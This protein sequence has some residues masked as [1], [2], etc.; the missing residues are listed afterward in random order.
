MPDIWILAP[1]PNGVCCDCSTR[2]N[3]CDSCQG[4]VF[5]IPVPQVEG[6]D[7]FV[8]VGTATAIVAA[9]KASFTESTDKCS[10][11]SPFANPGFLS[12]THILLTDQGFVHP[13]NVSNDQ[14]NSFVSTST[15]VDGASAPATETVLCL[16][17]AADTTVRF[18]YS[19]QTDPDPASSPFLP[20]QSFNIF[21]YNILG[22][23]PITFSDSGSPNAVVGVT[24]L[25]V[26]KGVYYVVF[27]GKWNSV[28]G[29]ITLAGSDC[30]VQVTI[31][32]NTAGNMS[33]CKI[34]AQYFEGL[35]IKQLVCS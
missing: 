14:I 8:D 22:G 9:N 29:N 10:Q 24:T 18:D 35:E 19:S 6:D 27:T 11:Y 2:A 23:A 31:K 30:F 16:S 25:T 17:F 12:S 32:D 20:F 15:T 21:L 3:P 4:C 26:P 33:I 28:G 7:V 1:D 5:H 13:Y 34:S